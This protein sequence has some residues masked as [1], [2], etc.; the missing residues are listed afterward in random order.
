ME[1]NPLYPP[2]KVLGQIWVH[3]GRVQAGKGARPGERGQPARQRDLAVHGARR[4]PGGLH[5]GKDAVRPD[6]RRV[7]RPGGRVVGEPAHEIMHKECRAQL[8]SVARGSK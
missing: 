6:Q 2:L 1:N 4:L 7:K 5:R 3:V 8:I